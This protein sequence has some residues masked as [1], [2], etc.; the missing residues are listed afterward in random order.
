[1][2]LALG[3]PTK[4]FVD[5]VMGRVRMLQHFGVTPYL[6]FDGDHLPGKAATEVDRAKKREA[7]RIRGTELH[8]Q[9]RIAQA[10]AE[11]QKAV[12][13]TPEM[14][15]LVID[16]LKRLGVQYV[17]APYEADAQLVYLERK[18]IVSAIL[19]ED[20][21]LLVFGA[22]CLLTKLDQRGDCVE[23]RRANFGGCKAVTLAG[24]SDAEFRRMAILSGCDYLASISQM[25]LKTAHRLV[26]K[27]KTVERIVKAVQFDGQLR[28]PAGYLQ[29][30]RGA[31]ATF[32]HQRV[33][34]P[35][36]REVV[37]LTEPDA[38]LDL[39]L[40]EGIGAAVSADVGLGVATGVLHPMSKEELVGPVRPVAL[41]KSRLSGRQPVVRAAPG[42]PDP[43]KGPP[44]GLW[45][46][47][48]FFPS[49]R[50]PLAE[51]K[52]NPLSP[53]AHAQTH[54]PDRSSAASWL[55]SPV[56]ANLPPRTGDA[57]EPTVG[58]T[59][60]LPRLYVGAAS[61]S[62]KRKRLC[63]DDEEEVE[64]AK[65][66][67]PAGLAGTKSRFFEPFF[68]DL[69]APRGCGGRP[70]KHKGSADFN[71]FSD[72]SFED[73]LASFATP[74]KKKAKLEVFKDSD[75]PSPAK[76]PRLC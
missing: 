54:V 65:K 73:A 2:E 58:G 71:L 20:S 19:S 22:R 59:V 7:A 30:F 43:P 15:R 12:D 41:P 63:E 40:L 1:M 74:P 61:P 42:R 34:C 26:R 24:W 18:G 44:K 62:R 31:E 76:K 51:L 10:N 21:D 32:L 6:V 53:A 29:E 69:S 28:V 16:E 11:L 52:V 8:A 60:V 49:S 72:E 36:R 68:P 37:M 55:A 48:S 47:D 14:T 64:A 57:A 75:K 17:V 66:V 50:R 33:F 3:K 45:P 56:P 39:G 13:V 35:I 27:Y 67:E 4:R 23:I 70:S 46:I 38:G 5:Y 25:G 9:G